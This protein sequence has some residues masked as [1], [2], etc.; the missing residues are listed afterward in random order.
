MQRRDVE[1]EGRGPGRS[2]ASGKHRNISTAHASLQCT[3][4]LQSAL[5]ALR[6]AACT[7]Q[8]V[9]GLQQM[10][11]FPNCR[12]LLLLLLLSILRSPASLLCQAPR[13]FSRPSYS[14]STYGV[15]MRP[16]PCRVRRIGHPCHPKTTVV[17]CA[18]SS[19][20]LQTTRGERGEGPGIRKRLACKLLAPCH[21]LLLQ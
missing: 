6:S 14:H 13:P 15:N 20:D 17:R 3:D 1:T 7:M 11:R 19:V 18:C 2:T 4:S 9:G 16:K 12:L 21:V 10:R 5:C 8:S